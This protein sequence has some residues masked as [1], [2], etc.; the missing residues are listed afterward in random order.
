MTNPTTVNWAVEDDAEIGYLL[1]VDLD[2]PQGLH[3]L[4]RDLPFCAERRVPHHRDSRE[5]KLL[6]TLE[7]KERYVLHYRALKQA[8]KNGLKLLKIHRVLEFKQKRW[9]KPYIDENTLKRA[10]ARNEFEKYYYKLK[11]NAVFGKTMEDERKRSDVRLVKNWV[12]RYGVEA[13]IGL[14]NFHSISVFGSSLAAIQMLRTK[15]TIKKPKYVGQAVLDLSKTL[16]YE[17]HYGFMLPEIGVKRLKL[18]YMDT[19]SFLY[20]ITGVDAY[21]FMKHHSQHFDTSDYPNNNKYGIEPKYA[22]I[23]GLFKDELNGRIILSFVGLRSKMYAVLAEQDKVL[24]KIKGV[25]S[26]VVENTI[27]FDDFLHCLHNNEMIT[28]DQLSIRSRLHI[29]RTERETKTVLN[30]HDDKRY[31]ILSCSDTLPWG[32]YKIQELETT[33]QEEESMEPPTKKKM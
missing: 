32:H 28:R 12:G 8:L 9:L 30:P 21:A 27:T 22:K 18:L 11:N 25:K 31:L 4:H 13:L 7:K 17:F 29:L 5:K 6:T 2:Y 20:F 24:K 14:P 3:D 26:A 33:R 10:N 23:V 16:M 1:E 19:D 15:I